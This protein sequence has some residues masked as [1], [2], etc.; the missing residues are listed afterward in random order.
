MSLLRSDNGVTPPPL[1]AAYTSC[2]SG[3][4][5]PGAYSDGTLRG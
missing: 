1:P 4:T 5:E 3:V 2:L